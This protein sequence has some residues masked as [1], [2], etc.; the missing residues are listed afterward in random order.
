METLDWLLELS[1]KSDGAEH[2]AS[3][4]EVLE[5]RLDAMDKH[6]KESGKGLEDLGTRAKAAGEKMGQ[7]LKGTDKIVEGSAAHM[8]HLRKTVED[9]RRPQ[10]IK[11]LQKEIKDLRENAGHAKHDFTGLGEAMHSLKAAVAGFTL[12]EIGKWGI[13]SLI[14]KT[15]EWGAELI[16]AAAGEQRTGMVFRNQFGKEGGEA[17]IDWVEGMEKNTEFGEDRLK[18]AAAQLG[19]GKSGFRG[20]GLTK[21]MAAALDMASFDINAEEGL[22]G[23]LG[24]LTKIRR[25]GKVDNRTLAGMGLGMKDFAE[26]YAERTGKGKAAVAK[27]AKV[28]K[29][30]SEEALETL[31]AVIM[32]RTGKKLGGAGAEMGTTLNARMK[33]LKEIPEQIMES[34]SKTEAFDRFSD[35]IDKIAQKLGPDS[36]VGQRIAKF[37]EETTDSLSRWLDDVD[38]DELGKDAIG[39]I[40]AIRDGAK[41]MAEALG[42]VVDA[43]KI[44]GKGMKGINYLAHK[45]QYD[46]ELRDERYSLGLMKQYGLNRADAEAAARMVSDSGKITDPGEL[47]RRANEMSRQL[48]AKQAEWGGSLW[49]SKGSE[50]GKHMGTGIKEGAEKALEIHSP[51]KVF[52]RMGEQAAAGFEQGMSSSSPDTQA[53]VA[54]AIYP[55]SPAPTMALGGGITV[56]IPITVQAS[57]H[58][59]AEDIVRQLREQILPSA[60]Q[61]L[62]EQFLIQLGVAR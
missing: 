8:Q 6:L 35:A 52:A 53:A 39:F 9:L 18:A 59:S 49:R 27:L 14:E 42:P 61:S 38:W 50:Y 16:K 19:K 60:V 1:D 12:F 32:K 4:L 45:D 34:W 5:K 46:A 57:E 29:L 13:E 48:A 3:R 17:M 36:P 11:E 56:T 23:A 51:S 10:A 44:I 55:P 20:E 47:L 22:S 25:T 37:I 31:Y 58:A 41:S 2:M 54:D 28:G 21:A 24:A 43:F 30:D 26:A 40:D 15:K 33:N 62:L 7:G